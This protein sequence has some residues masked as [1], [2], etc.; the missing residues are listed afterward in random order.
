MSG[1]IILVDFDGVL[2]SYSSGW[3]G[4]DV[5]PDPPVKG[6]LTWLRGLLKSKK[7]EVTIYSAR[8]KD[9]SGRKAMARWLEHWWEIE[10]LSREDLW[11]LQYPSQK[12]A[13]FLTIDDRC[14]Q[15][16]GPGTFP[17]IDEIDGFKP[18]NKRGV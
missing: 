14:I 3:Q 10:G 1:K 17:T 9:P 6:A 16:Q 15:F 18:W 12:P 11:P 13:A 2:H 7:F 4:V 5:I 8:S